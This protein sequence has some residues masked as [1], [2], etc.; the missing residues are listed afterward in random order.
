MMIANN[1][2]DSMHILAPKLCQTFS[3]KQSEGFL[4][5]SKISFPP[6]TVSKCFMDLMLTC[7]FLH[8]TSES[9]SNPCENDLTCDTLEEAIHRTLGDVCYEDNGVNLPLT[10]RM[11][12]PLAPSTMHLSI[13]SGLKLKPEN[14]HLSSWSLPYQSHIWFSECSVSNSITG[15]LYQPENKRVFHVPCFVPLN[16]TLTL[17][18]FT[19]TKL[20]MDQC[21]TNLVAQKN[22]AIRVI[23]IP[24][25]TLYVKQKTIL[26]HQAA[27]CENNS[28][29]QY[30]YSRSYENCLWCG[31][32]EKS[33]NIGNT[34]TVTFTLIMTTEGL[35]QTLFSAYIT[36]NPLCF[37]WN[38]SS[39]ILLS[40]RI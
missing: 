40:D 35:T 24:Y 5:F 21:A 18:R 16:V 39:Y 6:S 2:S 38:A 4:S 31:S 20:V 29:L 9:I 33:T 34:A 25:E 13:A 26:Q 36:E 3:T 8:S 10:L 19:T 23:L 22:T 11:E 28:I 1:S 30:S 27:S 7:D 15:Q 37:I 32:L 17:Q 14:N 12:P